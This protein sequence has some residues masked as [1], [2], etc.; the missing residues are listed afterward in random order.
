MKIIWVHTYETGTATN[1]KT[2]ESVHHVYDEALEQQ[3]LL[4]GT[5]E[6]FNQMPGTKWFREQY[7]L[8]P[9]SD[10]NLMEMT[11]Q[12]LPMASLGRGLRGNS[13]SCIMLDFN[14]GENK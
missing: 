3:T 14:D 12:P 1:R 8:H 5:V 2:I 6:E 7:L 11:K 10:Q 13:A 9:K 4:G